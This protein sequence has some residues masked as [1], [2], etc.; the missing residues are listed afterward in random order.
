MAP[1]APVNSSIAIQYY[2]TPSS[3]RSIE[4][5]LESLAATLGSVFAIHPANKTFCLERSSDAR[6][7]ILAS[8]MSVLS[9]E[10]ETIAYILHR[11]EDYGHY[12]R[13]GTGMREN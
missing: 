6:L 1:V 2:S 10:F 11:T 9:P 4:G 12:A 5:G 8:V 13:P 3:L 7:S